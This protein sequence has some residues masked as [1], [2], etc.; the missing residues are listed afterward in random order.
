MTNENWKNEK[1]W[2]HRTVNKMFGL[3]KVMFNYA[4]EEEYISE[5]DNPVRK[6]KKLSRLMGHYDT[7]ITSEY[8][9]GL[10]DDAVLE[11]GIQSSSL[12]NL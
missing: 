1:E 6:I 10:Q 3:I 7:S 9:R 11:K 8:L 12:S 5:Q 2:A 4:V